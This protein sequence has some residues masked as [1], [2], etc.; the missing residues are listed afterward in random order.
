MQLFALDEKGLPTSADQAAKQLDYF[1]LECSSVV[2]VRGGIHRRNHFYH[3]HPDRICRQNGKSLT[4]LQVQC[5]IR[6]QLPSGECVLERRFADI[7]R[8]ADVAW[9]SEKIIFEIQCSPITAEEIEARN[10]DYAQ[11]GY[12]VVWILH[13][14]R[15]NRWRMTAAENALMISPHYYTNIGAEGRGMIYDQLCSCRGGL[16]SDRSAAF[17][18]QVSAPLKVDRSSSSNAMLIQRRLQ[19]WNLHFEGDALDLHAA[20]GDVFHQEADL[21]ETACFNVQLG[22]FGFLR[23]LFFQAI[24]RGSRYYSVFLRYFVEKACR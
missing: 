23:T 24:Y 14:A 19:N 22:L 17:P 16:R 11:I 18:I 1:C 13:D 9:E 21:V 5:Y 15:Y 2:R 4:H 7:G 12:E 3:M 20:G 10:R 6:D 8:I